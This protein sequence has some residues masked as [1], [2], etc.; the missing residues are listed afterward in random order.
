VVN[1]STGAALPPTAP[2][3]EYRGFFVNDEDM[4]SGFAEV[5]AGRASSS[6][7]PRSFI[8]R[9]PAGEQSMAVRGGGVTI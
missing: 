2:A 8:W 5:G 9:F 1:P 3:F 7:H 4:L 6:P